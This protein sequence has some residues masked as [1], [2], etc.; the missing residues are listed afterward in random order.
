MVDYTFLNIQDVPHDR[1][2]EI[3]GKLNV[4][5]M[6]FFIDKEKIMELIRPVDLL[7][8]ICLII[9]DLS[10]PWMIKDSLIKW[11]KLI[12]ESFG[13]LI[14]KLPESVQKKIKDNGKNKNIN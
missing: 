14:K 10:R 13:E 3:I 4:W 6:N 8:S 11:T 12:E 1:N 2:S 9:C 7:N 5:I